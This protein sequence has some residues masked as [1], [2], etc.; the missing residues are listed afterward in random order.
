MSTM[1]NQKYAE[2]SCAVATFS[3]G[4]NAVDDIRSL[5]D[6]L[7]CLIDRADHLLQPVL[8]SVVPSPIAGGGAGNATPQQQLPP[9][10]NDLRS[11]RND[12]DSLLVRLDQLLD[13]VTL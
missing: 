11:L 6:R 8:M 1:S 5:N 12:T 4:S 7:G 13:R 2:A 9:L 10:F 3:P